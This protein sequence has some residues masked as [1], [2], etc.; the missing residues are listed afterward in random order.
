LVIPVRERASELRMG[1]APIAIATLVDENSG[2]R[3]RIH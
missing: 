2:A 3:P 1:S